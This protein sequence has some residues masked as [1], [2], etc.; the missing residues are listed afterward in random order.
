M[1]RAANCREKAGE[2]AA[3]AMLFRDFVG[4]PRKAAECFERGGKL[5]E[6]AAMWAELGE[7]V[8]ALNACIKGYEWQMALQLLQSFTD[9]V[10]DEGPGARTG[11]GAGAGVDA[12]AVADSGDRAVATDV[13]SG[14][15]GPGTD[16]AVAGDGSVSRLC[17][18]SL[19]SCVRRAALNCLKQG[20]RELMQAF[21][22]LLPPASALQFFNM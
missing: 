2:W 10:A 9:G 6:A 12:G 11:T 4:Q 7:Q 1:E 8:K 22:Q 16:A 15:V 14:A 13:V 5:R 20:R 3:A 18:R 19:E 17:P 21:A